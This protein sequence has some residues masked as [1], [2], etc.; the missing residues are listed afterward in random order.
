MAKTI[1]DELFEAVGDLFEVEDSWE[2]RESRRR[3][4]ESRRVLRDAERTRRDTDRLLRQLRETRP[5]RPLVL[6]PLRPSSVFE[7]AEVLELDTN[8]PGWGLVEKGFV[9]IESKYYVV[10]IH[11]DWDDRRFGRIWDAR[12]D[13]SKKGV[14]ERYKCGSVEKALRALIAENR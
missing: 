14:S 1:F 4:E 8:P 11:E 13:G 9:R 5:Y 3:L 10:E 6:P 12:R 7:D 2:V